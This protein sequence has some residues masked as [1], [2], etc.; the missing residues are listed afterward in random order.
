MKFVIPS[1]NRPDTQ[2]TLTYL[3]SIGYGKRDIILQV[4]TLRDKSAYEQLYGDVATVLYDAA[5]RFSVNANNAL[6]RLDGSEIVVVMDDDIKSPMKWIP[7]TTRLEVPTRSQFDG[8]LRKLLS[9][10]ER[11]G[12]RIGTC[13]ASANGLSIRGVCKNGEITRNRLSSG[14]LIIGKAGDIRFD[15]S[16]TSCEDYEIQLREISEGRNIVRLNSLAPNTVSR[17]RKNGPQK[18]GRGFSY[19]DQEHMR[20]IR[21]VVGMYYPI[22]IPSRKGTAIRINERYV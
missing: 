19:Q 3:N 5:D 13:Y 18:G 12:A 4:Q 1:Y 8:S 11:F 17:Q 21:R 6:R 16:L 2:L 20:N 15:E 22:G 14:W 10:M 7:N 9:A